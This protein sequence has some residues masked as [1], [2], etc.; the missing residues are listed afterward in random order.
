MLSIEELNNSIIKKCQSLFGI[1]GASLILSFD[2]YHDPNDPIGKLIR[3]LVNFILPHYMLSQ[4][5]IYCQMV[6]SMIILFTQPLIT[7]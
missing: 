5:R 1:L 7:K 2:A 4:S 6:K 3:Y